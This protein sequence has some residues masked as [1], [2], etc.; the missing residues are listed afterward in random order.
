MRSRIA[1][2][3][4][5]IAA[6]AG[7]APAQAV[8]GGKPA[9]PGQFPYV[10]DVFIGGAFGCSGTLIAPEWVLTAGHCGSATG[11][12]SE[13]LV[14]SPVAWPP[15]AYEVVLGTV[16]SDGH[17]GESHSVTD[18]EVDSDYFVTNGPGNDVTLM[19]LDKPTSIAPM[20]I[21]AVGE[22]DR[23]RPGALSTIAG[24]GTTSE[25][26]ND[27]PAQMQY[28]QVPIT[29]DDY[30]A[31]AYPGGLSTVADDGSFDPKTMLCAGYPQGGTD[32]CQG[33]SGG[34]LMVPATAGALRLVGATSF[35]NGCGK[36]GKPG[37]YARL[38]EGPI[39]EWIRTIVPDAFAPEPARSAKA[40]KRKRVSRR[41]ARHRRHAHARDRRARA[42]SCRRASRR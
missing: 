14:P 15:G 22:R 42:R 41:C 19:K 16:Y 36:P 39:R 13:G 26:S 18:V 11:S 38:A 5:S 31:K 25:N 23:W 20:K 10:A 1:A 7:A 4:L 32:T 24:F 6:L 34:P 17:G 40:N 37:V 28:A 12:L 9:S 21:A 3:V 27:P 2:T 33:D 35:G 29:T 30:C 8:V